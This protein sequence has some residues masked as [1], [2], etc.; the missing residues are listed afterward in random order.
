[1]GQPSAWSWC[2]AEL[3]NSQPPRFGAQ[4][5]PM[6]SSLW[7]YAPGTSCWY[8]RPLSQLQPQLQHLG[9]SPLQMLCD[10]VPWH[11]RSPATQIGVTNQVNRSGPGTPGRSPASTF[12]PASVP[13]ITA[14]GVLLTSLHQRHAAAHRVDTAALPPR[15]DASQGPSAGEFLV[16][17]H[18]SIGVSR[19]HALFV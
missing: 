13:S 18:V 7:V 16:A 9:S 6:P 14:P 15:A 11:P 10:C 2:K 1:M 8:A 12:A 4:P 17:A 5:R 19:P 3:P